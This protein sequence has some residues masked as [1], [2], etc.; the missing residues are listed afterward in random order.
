MIIAQWILAIIAIG[1][2]VYNTIVTHVVMRNDIKH[3]QEDC[4]KIWQKIDEL[5]KYLLEHRR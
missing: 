1:A 5:Y 3:L 2:V 4:E